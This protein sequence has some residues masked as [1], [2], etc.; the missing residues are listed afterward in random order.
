MLSEIHELK[1]KTND[2]MQTVLK[3]TNGKKNLDMLLA[4]QR[5]S[6]FKI[7]LG[8]DVLSKPP[9][10]RKNVVFIKSMHDHTHTSSSSHALHDYSYDMNSRSN[11]KYSSIVKSFSGKPKSKLIWVP[12]TNTNGPKQPWVPRDSFV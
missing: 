10:K 1:C 5:I 4:S 3:F 11:I 6:F 2:L 7:G 12:K 8:Y 9:L